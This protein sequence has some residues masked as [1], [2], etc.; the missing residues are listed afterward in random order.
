MHDTR[1]HRSTACEIHSSIDANDAKG[2]LGD[3]F[4]SRRCSCAPGQKNNRDLPVRQRIRR[5]DLKMEVSCR[6]GSIVAVLCIAL[7]FPPL[8]AAADA[9]VAILRATGPIVVDGDLSDAPWQQATRFDTWYETNP[10]DNVPP[11][12]HQRG[13]VTYD[14]R[15]FYVALQCDD[16][17][18][19][20][21]RAPFGDHDAI[22]GSNDDFAGVI[23]RA[24]GSDEDRHGQRLLR[25]AS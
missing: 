5:N 7:F 12:I 20:Q 10:G 21:I 8:A 19:E 25:S 15:F 2:I 24:G 4:A 22:S 23:P 14:D 18:P 11:F 16:P 3:M 9:P 13:R 1:Q 17:H 6:A